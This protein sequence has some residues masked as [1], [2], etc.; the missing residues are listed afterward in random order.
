MWP[1]LAVL[2]GR[3]IL[4]PA[5]VW[6]M[7]TSVL[8]R[9]DSVYPA[10][11]LAR[12]DGLALGT[13]LAGLLDLRSENHFVNLRVMNISSRCGM[14]KIKNNLIRSLQMPADIGYPHF[15]TL[16]RSWKPNAALVIAGIVG[17]LFVSGPL[18]QHEE[19]IPGI[20]GCGPWSILAVNLV[21]FSVVGLIVLNTGHLLL[22]P[23]RWSPLLYIGRVSYG[24]YLYNF[25]VIEAIQS[26]FGCRSLVTDLLAAGLSVLAG[27]ISWEVLEKPLCNL[28][29]PFPLPNCTLPELTAVIRPT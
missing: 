12:I 23:L 21:Y 7:V 1:L 11:A 25:S 20:S 18:A 4:F 15:A 16:R 5:A 8:M 28:K 29:R 22:S 3:P 9:L 14:R 10:V 2:V 13:I 24:I 27:V 19:P 26:Y 6:L 17:L